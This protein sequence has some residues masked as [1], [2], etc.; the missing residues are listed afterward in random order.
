MRSGSF[1][2]IDPEKGA[3]MQRDPEKNEVK[4][5]QEF[6][7]PGSGRTLEIG[8]GNGRLT[9]D[10]ARFATHLVAVDPDEDQVA[11]ARRRVGRSAAFAVASG[12][13]LPLHADSL[14]T[15]VFTLSLHHQ[16]PHAALMEACRALKRA[17]RVVVL[18]PVADSPVSRLFAVLE[19][20]SEKYEAVENAIAESG[21]EVVRRGSVSTRWVFAN[22]AEVVSYLFGYFDLPPDSEKQRIMLQL[23]GDR[24]DL[25]PLPIEDIT[26]FWLLRSG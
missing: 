12:E 16:E 3:A 14:D 21:L 6:L 22:K 23:L 24:Q 10:L 20:E 26:R 25:T 9:V 13:W 18:E 1:P 19:D 7:S 15:V 5:L 8:C 4:L 17:G 2:G 11:S